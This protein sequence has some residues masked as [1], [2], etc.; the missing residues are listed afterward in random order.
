M[1]NSK[2]SKPPLT[3]EE[4]E[5]KVEAFLNLADDSNI[6]PKPLKPQKPQKEPTKAI[7][8]RLP[9]SL[10]EE[11]QEI[12]ALTGLSMNAVCME[13]LRPAVKKKLKELKEE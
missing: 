6:Q 7:L 1:A 9:Q 5:K 13:L 2:F 11:V 8:L 12:A 4:K 10:L 3:K